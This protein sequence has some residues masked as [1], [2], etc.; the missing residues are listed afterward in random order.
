MI[1]DYVKIVP[2]LSNQFNSFLR[3][4]VKKFYTSFCKIPVFFVFS[5]LFL[6]LFYFTTYLTNVPQK[7]TPRAYA[8]GV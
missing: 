3:F 4:S 1:P 8:L 5:V 6:S 2:H 7:E